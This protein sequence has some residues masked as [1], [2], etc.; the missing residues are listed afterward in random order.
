[1]LS[2]AAA[3][4]GAIGVG[5]AGAIPDV[6]GIVQGCYNNRNGRLRAVEDPSECNIKKESPIF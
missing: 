2:L 3:L 1:M 5:V 6:N 4:A